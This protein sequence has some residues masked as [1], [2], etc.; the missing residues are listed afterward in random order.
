METQK[1]IRI[2][3]VLKLCQLYLFCG[4]D[5]IGNIMTDDSN[6]ESYDDDRQKH[7]LIN[8]FIK[9]LTQIMKTF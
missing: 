1:P 6:E 9:N 5:Q 8:K 7:P 3:P 4:C 2:L